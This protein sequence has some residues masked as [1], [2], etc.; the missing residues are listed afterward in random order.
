MIHFLIL[1]FI[2]T[3]RNLSGN[4]IS[5]KGGQSKI[6]IKIKQRAGS[7]KKQATRKQKRE[8]K[9][10]TKPLKRREKNS[11]KVKNKKR[12]AHTKNKNENQQKTQDLTTKKQTKA[13][14]T[15][16]K[17]EY[18]EKKEQKT[19]SINKRNSI[20]HSELKKEENKESTGSGSIFSFLNWKSM[21]IKKVISSLDKNKQYPELAKE[22]GI[23]GTVKLLLTINRNGNVEKIKI[24]ESSGFPIL[25]KNAIE[26]AKKSKFPPF[27]EEIKKDDIKITIF[28]S[29][30]LNKVE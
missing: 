14:N 26:T 4:P 16:K 23:Q 25:D 2:D 29:Y 12:T 19:E 7:I 18:I 20:S 15:D 9:S 22:M 13:K 27:P 10:E 30:K 5:L 11:D 6:G 1:K 8:N 17:S 28:I 21:Y 24:A 3:N